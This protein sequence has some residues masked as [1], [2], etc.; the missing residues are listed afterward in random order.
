MGTFWSPTDNHN[1]ELLGKGWELHPEQ[2]V[3]SIVGTK[4]N[5]FLTRLDLWKPFRCTMDDLTL[6]ELREIDYD[7][8]KQIQEE[9]KQKVKVKTYVNKWQPAIPDTHQVGSYQSGL[10]TSTAGGEERDKTPEELEKEVEDRVAQ[11]ERGE[12]WQDYWDWEGSGRL[13][14]RY[15]GGGI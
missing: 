11:A 3:L 7:L 9:V 10:I 6:Y 8:D 1:I 4:K 2:W 13:Y 15:P 5:E 12:A 14:G